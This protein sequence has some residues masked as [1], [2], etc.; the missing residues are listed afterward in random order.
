[1]ELD[2]GT[3]VGAELEV[4]GASLGEELGGGKGEDATP[5]D[6]EAPPGSEAPLG[7]ESPP[8]SKALPEPEESPAKVT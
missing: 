2:N 1:M 7:S 6:S 4:D 8:G 3:S 5:P